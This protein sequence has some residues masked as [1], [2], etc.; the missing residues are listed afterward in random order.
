[1]RAKGLAANWL[2]K[3]D[4]FVALRRAYRVSLPDMILLSG[5]RTTPESE[6][7]APRFGITVTRQA[8][9]AV[10]RNRIRRRLRRIIAEL[11]GKA[12]P[13]HDHVLIAKSGALTAS[14]RELAG[15][16]ATG[17]DRAARSGKRH[18]PAPVTIGPEGKTAPTGD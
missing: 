2:R 4:E 8:A 15:Q 1:M 11:A 7:A 12:R 13:G 5:H 10:G 16:L 3:R 9:N 18:R 6:Q 17:L 14:Y